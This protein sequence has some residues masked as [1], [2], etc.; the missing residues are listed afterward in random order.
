MSIKM[1][2]KNLFHKA[3][4]RLERQNRNDVEKKLLNR[5]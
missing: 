5:K 4:K 3:Q 1:N 2:E